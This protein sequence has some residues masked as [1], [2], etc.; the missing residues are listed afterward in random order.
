MPHFEKAVILQL[1]MIVDLNT[2]TGMHCGN[3]LPPLSPGL[4]SVS[5]CRVSPG[6]CRGLCA[7]DPDGSCNR[8]DRRPGNTPPCAPEAGTDPLGTP[9][10]GRHLGCRTQSTSADGSSGSWPWGCFRCRPEP[11]EYRLLPSP[12]HPLRK[13][14]TEGSKSRS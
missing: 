12:S 5:R 8:R 6:R 14:N 7:R 10:R 4:R 3:V 1:A 9:D 13:T 11:L 2:C